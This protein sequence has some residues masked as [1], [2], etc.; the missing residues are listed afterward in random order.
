MAIKIK[1]IHV[2]I[3]DRLIVVSRGK[4]EHVLSHVNENYDQKIEAEDGDA[5]ARGLFV[6][7]IS[8]GDGLIWINNIKSI[9]HESFHATSYIMSYVGVN[10]HDCSEEAYAY[11]LDYIVDQV[12]DKT[13]WQTI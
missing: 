8:G 12:K 11:L 2:P 3:Y 10:H 4:L 1:E 5:E 9:V 13:G 7:F 6:P